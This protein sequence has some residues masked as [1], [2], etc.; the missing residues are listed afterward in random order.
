MKYYA[1]VNSRFKKPIIYTNWDDCKSIVSGFP[2][3]LYKS[4]KTK[5]EAE[6]YIKKHTNSKGKYV[7]KSQQVKKK[8]KK[9]LSSD[10][11]KINMYRSVY[12]KKSGSTGENVVET[13]LK[14]HNFSYLK[15]KAVKIN[16]CKH[17]FDFAICENGKIIGFIEFD[18][19]QHYEEVEKFGG[20]EGL[21]K[22]QARDQ[23]KNIFCD[24]LGYRLLR[25]KYSD[26][27]KSEKMILDTFGDL[28]RFKYKGHKA[29]KT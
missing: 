28:K 3:A 25:I 11:K 21:I 1:V 23:D 8:K 5:K 24:R 22:R 20:K 15:E 13:Y 12:E 16:G 18:G 14:I 17:I 9:P 2:N 7:K 10:E 26:G 29:K 4:F 6:D 19:K 27:R